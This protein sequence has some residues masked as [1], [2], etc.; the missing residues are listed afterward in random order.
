MAL[1]KWHLMG[2]GKSSDRS[3]PPRL[4]TWSVC[5][6]DTAESRASVTSH[7][8]RSATPSA[9]LRMRSA[10][11]FRDGARVPRVDIFR[12]KLQPFT[13]DTQRFSRRNM[14]NANN[15]IITCILLFNI[16]I[17]VYMSYYLKNALPNVRC[18]SHFAGRLSVLCS[19]Q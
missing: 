8:C 14:I 9:V 5:L 2:A 1:K 10:S 18:L 12:P 15:I 11:C 13:T 16:L 17:T 4:T 7:C 19:P 6:C 3:E